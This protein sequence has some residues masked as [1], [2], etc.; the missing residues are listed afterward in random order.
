[1]F[2]H[3]FY[4]VLCNKA[5][6]V[7]IIIIFIINLFQLVWLEDNKYRYSATSYRELWEDLEENAGD[8]TEAWQAAAD[9]LNEQIQ[10]MRRD[11]LETYNMP[12]K[13]TG[14]V[15]NEIDLYV[16]VI[17]EIESSLGYESYLKGI[18]LTKNRYLAL[19][20]L[21]DKNNYVYRNLMKTAELYSGIESA[22]TLVPEAS[23]GVKMATG[24]SV[25]DFLVFAL[26]IFFG[27]NVWLKE[28]EQG[29]LGVIRTAR[30]GR[31]RL[32]VTKTGT[33]IAVCVLCAA[34][35]YISNII[36]AE[37]YYGLGDMS[38]T[39]AT[40]DEYRGTLWQ[41]SVSEFFVYN[42]II[43]LAAFVWLAL[44]MSVVCV[45]VS[46]SMA[47]FGTMAL[48][49]AGSY[50]MYTN[51]PALSGF[52]VFKYLNPF[53]MIKTELI[54]QEFRGINILGYPFDYRKCV[55]AV[56][57]VGCVLFAFITVR[58]FVR[59]PVMSGRYFVKLMGRA[60]GIFT[61]IR[62]RFERHVSITGHEFYR[63][64]ISGGIVWVV[65]V[66]LAIQISSGQTYRAG[67]RN[68]AEYYQRQYLEELSGAVTEDKIAFIRSEEER[69]KHATDENEQE[70]RKALQEIKARL[71]YLEENEGTY[72]VYDEPFGILTAA[73]IFNDD[74]SQAVFYI[75][76]LALAMPLFF[77][78]EWQTGMRK[79]VS[80]ALHGKRRLVH[81]RYIMGVLLVM[82]FF[83]IT[84]LPSFVQTF[85][86]YDMKWETFAYPAGSLPHLEKFGTGI[87]IG[88]Y[89]VLVY[90]S[91]FIAGV[92][93]ALFIYKI[94][95]LIKSHV[96]TMAAAF[97]VFLIPV[98]LA[99][100]DYKL[101]F[102]AYP[103]SAFAGNMFLQ[104]PV[105][106]VT[107]VLTVAVISAVL[108]ILEK[109]KKA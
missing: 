29:M 48:M 28:K 101:E 87:S 60:V 41:I 2:K 10:V 106:A 93:A 89:M 69:L 86:S 76:L 18:E 50:V 99:S 75:T 53:G 78:P 35:L 26:F 62:R 109:R 107:C 82:V 16:R 4:K 91:R 38:R 68:M 57:I 92:L 83:L 42:L 17:S 61:K 6:I 67:Y 8:S 3:E 80:V 71:S 24:S 34:L 39:I 11:I 64:F 84:Y 1:M 103:Y 23:A 73:G 33:L 51:I 49:C 100:L 15:L 14:S 74:L 9:G 56:L 96:N 63:I 31:E 27:I 43:K 5:S 72:F 104:S 58:L 19:G 108:L 52:A 22:V 102:A 65:L 59:T 40:V 70:Q 32:A 105:A 45:W 95:A 97:G 36:I 47:A 20:S 30:N 98:L 7:F 55:A 90:V 81:V 66:A 44:L 37:L 85:C 77:A 25:T 46:G 88:I 13:Y 54:F 79:V 94:S 12:G 21:M